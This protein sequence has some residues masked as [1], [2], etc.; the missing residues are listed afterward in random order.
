MGLSKSTKKQEK[1][2]R[3]MKQFLILQLVLLPFLSFGQNEQNKTTLLSKEDQ[4][5]MGENCS[6]LIRQ[7]ELWAWGSNYSGELGDGSLVSKNS[8]VRI[9]K[10]SNWSYIVSTNGRTIGLKSDGSLWTWGKKYHTN[11]YDNAYQTTPLEIGT[12]EV[13]KNISLSYSRGYG[14]K[15]DGT[16]WIWNY[17]STGDGTLTILPEQI[18]IDKDWVK[19][20][21]S[22]HVLALKS[23][24]SLWAWG[25]NASGQLGLGHK[26]EVTKP[27]KI[28]TNT[29]WLLFAQ[30][31]IPVMQ[32]TQKAGAGLGEE[33]IILEN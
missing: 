13:W 25:Y 22:S 2:S 19:V 27:T 14:I 11:F 28:Q 24:G 1:N 4:V 12:G 16:L 26:N 29:E 5:F 20:S 30:L 8:P 15:N 23:D 6:F 32:L 3:F 17:P 31:K 10:S 18:G 7:G 21:S 33:M 9:G